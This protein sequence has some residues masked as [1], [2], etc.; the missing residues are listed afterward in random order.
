M[1]FKDLPA[2]WI[3]RII[4]GSIPSFLSTKRGRKRTKKS[5]E[6]KIISLIA[7]HTLAGLIG[8]SLHPLIEDAFELDF[9]VDGKA[10]VSGKLEKELFDIIRKIDYN[11][12]K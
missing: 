12:Q 11:Q 3:T 7:S 4:P 8:W 5:L 9:W 1:K 10:P 6:D 2:V